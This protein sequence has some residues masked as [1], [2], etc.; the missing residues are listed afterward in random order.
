MFRGPSK[1]GD[2]PTQGE[3]GTL[4]IALPKKHCIVPH[5]RLIATDCSVEATGT[6]SHFGILR[7]AVWFPEFPV[8]AF[9]CVVVVYKILNYFLYWFNFNCNLWIHC[10][11][12]IKGQCLELF[13]KVGQWRHVVVNRGT[14]ARGGG[15][16]RT[17]PSELPYPPENQHFRFVLNKIFFKDLLHFYHRTRIK[18]IKLKHKEIKHLNVRQQ[19]LIHIKSG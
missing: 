3:G 17:E 16:M 8:A 18:R 9:M 12:L 11:S 5:N 19:V 10:E 6:T 2:A 14:T 7:R 13:W 15:G 1:Q 4:K